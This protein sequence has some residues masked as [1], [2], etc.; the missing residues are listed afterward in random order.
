[1]TDEE[2]AALDGRTILLKT[3]AGTPVSLGRLRVEPQDD[4]R[5]GRRVSVLFETET[6]HCVLGIP[7]ARLNDLPRTWDGSMYTYTL[8]SGDSLWM[9][10]KEPHRRDLPPAAPIVEAF[11]PPIRGEKREVQSAAS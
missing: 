10:A 1:M 2:L 8:P 7:A 11:P 3:L 5:A 9:P 4:L 6:M